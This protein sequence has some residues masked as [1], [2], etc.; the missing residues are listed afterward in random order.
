[1]SSR[2]WYFKPVEIRRA[3]KAVQSAGLSVSQVEVGR[4]GQ[5]VVNI[6]R[7]PAPMAQQVVADADANSR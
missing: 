2:N 3:I 4:D 5:I 6:A 1:V 7:Q